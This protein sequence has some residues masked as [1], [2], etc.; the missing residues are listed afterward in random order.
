MG[1]RYSAE[2]IIELQKYSKEEIEL[3][4]KYLSTWTESKPPYYPDGSTMYERASAVIYQWIDDEYGIADEILEDVWWVEYTLDDECEI[5]YILHFYYKNTPR[6]CDYESFIV[7][8][9]DYFEDLK[10]KEES[11]K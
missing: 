7:D 2:Q 4:T 1:Y 6:E 9:E 8:V 3:V 11:K 10:K 5:E